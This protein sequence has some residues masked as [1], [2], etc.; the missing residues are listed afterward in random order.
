MIRGGLCTDATST[1]VRTLAG[2]WG[3]FFHYNISN[4]RNISDNEVKRNTRDPRR[5]KS[6]TQLAQ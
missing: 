5:K 2:Y 1:G 4:I 3:E 6:R